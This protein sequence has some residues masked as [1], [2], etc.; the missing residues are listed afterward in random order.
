MRNSSPLDE[1]LATYQRIA[2]RYARRTFSSLARERAA[3]LREL[4]GQ[5]VLDAG[6]GTGFYSRLLAEAG[7]EVVALDLSRAM[8]QQAQA[9]GLER[10]VQ[11]DLLALP[12][13]DAVFDGLFASA[14]LVHL[15]RRLL[16]AALREL[17]RLLPDGGTLYLSLKGRDS[18]AAEE[19]WALA[20]EGGRRFYSYY[21]REEAEAL[22]RGSGFALIHRWHD[23]VRGEGRAWLGFLARA[24]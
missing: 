15:P 9:L 18:S 7:L 17:R 2:A 13:A 20:P 8:L 10:L 23:P 1:T 16:P 4:R 14:S 12:F 19:G 6:C 11:G 22:L 5:R 24:Q 3:F 21:T